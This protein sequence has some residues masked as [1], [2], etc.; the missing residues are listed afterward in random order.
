MTV[1]S[2]PLGTEKR[3]AFGRNWRAFLS[4]LD[5][6]RIQ[7][8]QRSLRE[9]LEVERLDGVSFLDAGSGSGLFSLAATGLGATRIHS[10]DCDPDSVECTRELKHRYRPQ[11]QSWIIERGNVLDSRYLAGLGEFDVVYCWGVLHHTGNLWRALELVTSLVRPEG[12]LF[13]AIYNDQGLI[14]RGWTAVKRVYNSGWLG[15]VLMTGV[16][17]S[18]FVGRGFLADLVRVRNPVAR[19]RQYKKRRGM[20]VLHDWRDWL[21]GYPFEV[22]SRQSVVRFCEDQHLRLI[23]L[24]SAGRTLGNNEFVFV[25][26]A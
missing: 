10:F 7:E 4:R 17:L 1:I 21:G 8:A 22:A 2:P 24:R 6:E 13:I 16:F 5:D 19:Y 25:K 3:F 11:M 20:S 12:K 23:K 18:Y 15:R 9:M 26:P 14:S